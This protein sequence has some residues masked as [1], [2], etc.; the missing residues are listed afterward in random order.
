MPLKYTVVKAHV[1]W[2]KRCIIH[3]KQKLMKGKWLLSK[4]NNYDNKNDHNDNNN[5]TNNKSIIVQGLQIKVNRI[6]TCSTLKKWMKNSNGYF[7]NNVWIKKWLWDF[8]C[9]LQVTGRWL[10]R[11]FICKKG[12]LNLQSPGIKANLKLTKGC[13]LMLIII[14]E[15]KTP[16]ATWM[17]TVRYDKKLCNWII[18]L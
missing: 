1:C 12:E 3:L 16:N 2:W 6:Q 8:W 17:L 11:S 7:I 5:N 18:G 15:P 13:S 9:T 10:A 4:N 14:F